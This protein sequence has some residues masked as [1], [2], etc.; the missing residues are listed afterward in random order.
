ME[1]DSNQK[2]VE[3]VSGIL[4][5]GES[6]PLSST[7][8]MALVISNL[9]I[10]E[11]DPANASNVSRV[12][13]QKTNRTLLATL[14]PAVCEMQMINYK[15]PPSETVTLVA[16]GPHPVHF[17]GYRYSTIP[18]SSSDDGL[19]EEEEEEEACE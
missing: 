4:H 8:T 12:F 18:E 9:C 7:E 13:A 17:I 6:I 5:H 3:F 16:E 2:R 1:E 19:E 15:V 14:V 10:P 11:I